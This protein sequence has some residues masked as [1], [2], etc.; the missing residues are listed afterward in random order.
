M[1]S[2]AQVNGSQAFYFFLFVLL[3]DTRFSTCCTQTATLKCQWKTG[4]TTDLTHWSLRHEWPSTLQLHHD[5]Q[6]HQTAFYNIKCLSFVCLVFQPYRSKN[7]LIQRNVYG[8]SVVWQTMICTRPG[9]QPVFW[10]QHEWNDKEEIELKMRFN[11]I[12]EHWLGFVN[13]SRLLWVFY[14]LLRNEAQR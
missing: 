2:R 11:P 14:F 8:C 1:N 3:E 12:L 5:I 13:I 6:L 9:V 7:K 10:K 4:A